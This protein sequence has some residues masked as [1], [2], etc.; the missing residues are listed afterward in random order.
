MV[1]ILILAMFFAGC[2]HEA[3]E[4]HADPSFLANDWVNAVTFAQF[5]IND[6]LSFSCVCFVLDE[7][8][9]TPLMACVT[10]E[11]LWDVSGLG[12]NDYYMSNLDTYDGT[13]DEF[14]A[15]ND[16]T[17]A[18]GLDTMDGEVITLTPNSAKDEFVFFSLNMYVN[19]FF[20]GTYTL[21]P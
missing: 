10:G 13:T 19:G 1:I 21:A 5:T 17:W 4:P 6:D 18:L 2:K 16:R 7:D 9:V 3:D 14:K 11:L 12:P 8:G 20:G 15:G